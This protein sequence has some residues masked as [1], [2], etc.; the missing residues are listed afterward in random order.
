MH[1]V[2]RLIEANK[3]L[4]FRQLHKFNLINDPEAESIAYEALYNAIMNYDASKGNKLSTVATV[5]IYNALGSYVRSLNVKRQL[6]TVSYNNIAYSDDSDEY[7]FVDL[8]PCS[9]TI[10]E[11]Y[12]K[13]EVGRYAIEAF[14][15]LYDKLANEKHKA[16]LKAW[17]DSEFTAQTRE[18]GKQVGVS[19]SYASQIINNFKY[20]LRK[21][22]EDIYYD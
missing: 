4:V 3:G 21:E 12:I 15:K 11:A 17:K 1:D 7:E 9:E 16:I 22:L 5:Y 20:N 19:Q 14:D 8:L 2:N 6:Q 18:I 10:E 13:K